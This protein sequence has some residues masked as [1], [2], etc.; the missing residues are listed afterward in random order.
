MQCRTCG[1]RNVY[2]ARF[3]KACDAPFTQEER[4]G[5]YK[6]TIWGKLEA[7]EDWKD[8]LTLN[9]FFSSWPV[10]ILTLLLIVAIGLF[11]RG[12]EGN[13][14]R[15]LESDQ[16]RIEA[17]DS[18]GEYYLYTEEDEIG[19]RFRFPHEVSSLQLVSFD[20]EGSAVLRQTFSPEEEVCIR[21]ESADWFRIEAEYVSD[22]AGSRTIFVYRPLEEQ[23]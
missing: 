19:L 10:R 4:D 2:Y 12:R 14:L 18:A 7:L 8:T 3:C 11:L 17:N 15:L 5:G 13:A 22:P 9:K 6:A 1:T 20:R 21:V 16:Y 23:P